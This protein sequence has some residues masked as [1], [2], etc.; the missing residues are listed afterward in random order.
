MTNDESDATKFNVCY[1]V[2]LTR[3][4]TVTRKYKAN[5]QVTIQHITLSCPL[6]KWYR[7]KY[8]EDGFS[9]GTKVALGQLGE[10]PRNGLE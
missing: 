6:A 2:K 1:L 10:R 5:R 4:I 9:N 7:R 8:K 3:I